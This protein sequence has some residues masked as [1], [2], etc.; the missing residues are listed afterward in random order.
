MSKNRKAAILKAAIFWIL[1]FI[2]S[3]TLC[4]ILSVVE[5]DANIALGPF[6]AVHYGSWSFAVFYGFI[7]YTIAVTPFIF[8]RKYLFI[9]TFFSILGWF[10]FGVLLFNVGV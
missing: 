2:I 5:L 3:I 4:F 6:L 1:Y 9:L 7:L 8:S 10:A